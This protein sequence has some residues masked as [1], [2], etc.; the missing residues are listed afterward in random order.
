MR[1]TWI[2]AVLLALLDQRQAHG[3]EDPAL[4]LG[5][6]SFVKR[7][8]HRLML[9]R[10]SLYIHGANQ[11]YL[12]Y[13]SQEMVDEVLQDAAA[14]GLNVLRTWAFC[15]GEW[16]DG[17]SLQPEP[18]VY[19]EATFQKLDYLI[20]RAEQLGLRLTLALTNYWTDFGGMDAYVRWS[21][22]ANS[23]DDFY[24][25]A[26]T[27]RLYKNY[28]T[29][30]LNRRNTLTGRAYKDEPAI[31]MWE[32]ANEP[33]ASKERA[34]EF[35]EWV[36]HMAGHIKSIDSNHLVST[37][38]EGDFTT[39]IYATNASPH[40]DAIS[41]HLYPEH[42]NFSKEKSLEYIE[43]HI[44]VARD[45]LKKPVYCGE[46][47]IKDQSLRPDIYRSWYDFFRSNSIDGTLFWIL[48]GQREDGSLY[49]DYDGFTVYYPESTNLIPMM[50]DYSKWAASRSGKMLD[51]TPPSLS[52]DNWQDDDIVGGLLNWGG[53]AEDDQQLTSVTGSPRRSGQSRH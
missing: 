34:K 39:D 13:K 19:N 22:T 51:V 6:D 8:G 17:Q 35:Y 47:G 1:V 44:R 20:Y 52:I 26:E 32:L 46:F 27:R 43:R 23:R 50:R 29:Y 18:G 12:F 40:I 49:P 31:L 7:E 42:W 9:D 30:V 5:F 4:S 2:F 16:H 3:S 10:Q 28:V 24:S 25:D 48:S 21:P 15:D 37:G 14:L 45:E 53:K 11:Y 38:S 41:F 36:D 33:R